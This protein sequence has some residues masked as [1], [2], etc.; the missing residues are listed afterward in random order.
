M[1]LGSVN[2]KGLLAGGVLIAIAVGG[3]LWERA[4]LPKPQMPE[5][6]AAPKEE[7]AAEVSKPVLA[8]PEPV[9]LEPEAEVV[10]AEMGVDSVDAENADLLA[11]EATTTS[12]VVVEQEPVTEN[13]DVIAPVMETARVDADGSAIIAGKAEPGQV[14]RILIDGAVAAETIADSAGNYAVLFDVDPSDAARVISVAIG[15]G[16]SV[17]VSE[18]DLIV[19][20]NQVR[21]PEP[22]VVA[23]VEQEAAD[24]VDPVLDVDVSTQNVTETNDGALSEVVAEI[25][26][27]APETVETV[28]SD[29]AKAAT[30]TGVIE[31]VKVAEATQDIQETVVE[32]ATEAQ[33]ELVDTVANKEVA[34]AQE[35]QDAQ[36]EEVAKVETTDEP[37]LSQVEASVSEEAVA[38]SDDTTQ[39]EKVSEAVPVEETQPEVAP[40]VLLASKEGVKVV[41]PSTEKAKD[42]TLDAISY[43]DQGDVTLSGR[44]NAEARVQIYLDNTLST[45]TASDAQGDWETNLDNVEPGVY[46]LRVDEVDA[47]SKVTSRIELPFKRED[48]E[49][50]AEQAELKAGEPIKSVTVQPGFT[51]WAI[52]RERYGEGILYVRVFDANRDKIRDPDLIY[53]GQIFDLPEDQV[54]DQTS[55][56]G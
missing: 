54:E 42:I 25:A 53:P 40:T 5:L 20:P 15:E 12:E 32:A 26:Q 16:D 33:Q 37:A 27:T 19:M 31:V 44:A 46:T 18:Q 28:K 38:L 11:D 49:K 41:Q 51:L 13:V 52:A 35:T 22:V 45:S 2:G 1:G 17:V 43:S 34:A 6:T 55:D 47:T 3:W 36:L 4:R 14:V 9:A 24:T 48:R 8:Q 29:D 21:Q 39:P 56:N 10:S 23:E 7:V 30:E 50:L